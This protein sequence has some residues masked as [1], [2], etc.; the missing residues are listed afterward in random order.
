M[1]GE[2]GSHFVRDVEVDDPVHQVET[3][4]GHREDDSGVLVDGGRGGSEHFVQ[5]FP[6]DDQRQLVVHHGRHLD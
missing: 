1:D 5:V 6:L 4:E 3:G 2:V